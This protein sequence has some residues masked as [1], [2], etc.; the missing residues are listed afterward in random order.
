MTDHETNPTVSPPPTNPLLQR[1]QQGDLTV[2]PELQ[3]ALTTHPEI[4]QEVGDLAEHAEMSLLTAI[5]GKNLLAK[6]SIHL[7]LA[8]LKDGLAQGTTSP[9]ESLLIARI[10]VC[11]LHVNHLE[12]SAARALVIDSGQ[13]RES[14]Y[15]QKCLDSANR[16]YLYAIRQLALVRKLLKKPSPPKRPEKTEKAARPS[17][18]RHKAIPLVEV[19]AHG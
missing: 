14:V 1:A 17:R 5:A 3:E 7:K 10:A 4:W 18:D 13:S 16:R 12:M 2:L 19:A 8:E 15:A 9:L 6:E 11:W